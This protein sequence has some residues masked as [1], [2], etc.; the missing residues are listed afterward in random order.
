M[1]LFATVGRHI[2]RCV[3]DF[4]TKSN[5][6]RTSFQTSIMPLPFIPLPSDRVTRASNKDK[7]PGNID[8]PQPRRTH[9][10]VEES[11]R[12]EEEK[13]RQEEEERTER[14]ETVAA[15]EDAQRR[16]DERRE[17]ERHREAD[18]RKKAKAAG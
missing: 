14:M 15:I 9:A 4:I 11:R 6:R 17:S 18:A 1:E 16:E 12:Q 8:R 10:E 13:A 5:S 7:H 2:D 3:T